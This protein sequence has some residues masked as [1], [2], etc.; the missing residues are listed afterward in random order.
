MVI[1]YRAAHNFVLATERQVIANQR[2][3]LQNQLQATVGV[4]VALPVGAAVAIPATAA[5]FTWASIGWSALGGG[6]V[7]TGFGIANAWLHDVRYDPSD[8][9]LDFLQGAYFGVAGKVIGGLGLSGTV[10][11]A[12]EVATFSSVGVGWG[13]VRSGRLDLDM[14]LGNT[15]MSVAL[16]GAGSGIGW[17]WSKAKAYWFDVAVSPADLP[18]QQ[19]AAVKEELTSPVLPPELQPVPR[20]AA[21]FSVNDGIP[22]TDELKALPAKIGARLEA[23]RIPL[24]MEGVQRMRSGKIKTKFYGKQQTKPDVGAQV[25]PNT[26]NWEGYHAFRKRGGGDVGIWLN[27][28]KFVRDARGAI[29]DVWLSSVLVHEMIHA[30]GGNEMAAFMGQARFILESGEWASIASAG[31]RQFYLAYLRG[32]LSD[33]V[34][35]V[36][37]GPETPGGIFNYVKKYGDR[38]WQGS[39]PVDP[40]VIQQGGFARTLQIPHA[41]FEELYGIG[42]V[43]NKPAASAP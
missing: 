12:T 36:G 29:N 4:M 38:T 5:E 39:A 11:A 41:G 34:I 2:L 35:A 10:K 16:S 14:V 28:D 8:A 1:N 19:P 43:A 23:S 30:M 32:R 42:P 40:W 22:V 24:V 27:I 31:W 26:L 9:P 21:A 6:A 13:A 20:S 18:P 3:V 17:V 37:A 15:V 33:A 25:Y 7:Q